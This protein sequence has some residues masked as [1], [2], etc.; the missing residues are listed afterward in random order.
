MN[1]YCV[2]LCNRF[3]ES[4]QECPRTKRC[5]IGESTAAMAIVAA[6]EL[7]PQ[8][9]PIGIEPSDLPICA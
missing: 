8:Y 4:E 1:T 5:Y 7:H 6:S 2:I 9:R 3:F